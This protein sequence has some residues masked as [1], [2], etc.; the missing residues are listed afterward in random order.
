MNHFRVEY[1]ERTD[2]MKRVKARNRVASVMGTQ[3]M[4]LDGVRQTSKQLI[5]HRIAFETMRTELND[6]NA[7]NKRLRA[8]A[9][10]KSRLAVA[11]GSG[12]ILM[13]VLFCVAFGTNNS[14]KDIITPE[15]EIVEIGQ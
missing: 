2:E 13:T 7:E 12:I 4:V 6:L 15:S 8:Q 9:Q 3:V 1:I 10:N 5:D 11:F 14:F